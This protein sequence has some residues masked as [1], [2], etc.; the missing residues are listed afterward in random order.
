MLAFDTETFLIRPGHHAPEL[1]CLSSYD[2]ISEAVGIAD[3]AEGVELFRQWLRL[4]RHIVA[5]NAAFDLAVMAAAGVP[6]VEIFEAL[7]DGIIHCTKIRQK[8][9]DIANG[10]DRH[11]YSLANLSE[12][13]LRIHVEKEDTYRLRYEELLSVPIN[14]WPDEAVDYAIKDAQICG[15]LCAHQNKKVEFLENEADQMAADFVLRLCSCWGI[16]TDEKAVTAL[17]NSKRAQ[18][19]SY[20]E[21][22][23]NE[24]LLRKNGTKNQKAASLRALHYFGDKAKKTA[25]GR[26]SLSKDV[27]TKCGDPAL[28]AYTEYSQC[29]TFLSKSIESMK[30]DGHFL[31]Q[32]SFDVLKATGR[33]GSANPNIQNIDR[34]G[35]VRDCFVPRKGFLFC[36][37]DFD[38]AELHTLAQVCLK[39]FG[40]SQLAEKLNEGLDVHLL[41]A[42]QVMGIDYSAALDMKKEG[43]PI[44]KE[45]RQ[46]AKAANFGFPGGMGIL[47]FIESA[48]DYGVE[49]SESDAR[50]LKDQ[51]LTQWPEMRDFFKH[52]SDLCYPDDAAT[53]VH[54]GSHRVRGGA[55]YT[56]A[57]NSFF[58]GLAAD[59]G[60]AA[61]YGVSR[62]CYA[63]PESPLFGS[64]IVNFIHDEILLETPEHKAQAAARELERVMC[65]TFN[66]YTPDVPIT[67]SPALMRRWIKGAES[68]IDENG[69]L[70]ICQ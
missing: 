31:V 33:T 63:E 61:L 57:C 42:A 55:K 65:E 25:T 13:L 14:E 30:A 53:I 67:A 19:E 3:A 7:D 70:S 69:D 35:G 23:I 62:A 39:L 10:R 34:E 21:L 4:K 8:L 6:V 50:A 66:R 16:K 59:A 64:R 54:M 38:G 11:S 27:L 18:L 20:R 29:Q 41:F 32:T 47:R 49:I 43:E 36:A 24:G 1:V 48:K 37:C 2:T 17:E 52:V 12:S 26:V 40:H 15:K 5:H 9:I 45:R 28:E 46:G 51:W 58:Q 44:I 68:T 22:L 56:E 60:K